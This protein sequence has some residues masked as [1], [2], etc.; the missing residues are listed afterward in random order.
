MGEICVGLVILTAA[1][2]ATAVIV[3][4]MAIVDRAVL[5]LQTMD[6]SGKILQD[7]E[8]GDKGSKRNQGMDLTY[9]DVISAADATSVEHARTD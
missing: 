5:N 4:Y 7:E 3:S 9:R 8:L 2:A 6:V 1:G